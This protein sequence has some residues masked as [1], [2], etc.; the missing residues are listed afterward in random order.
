MNVATLTLRVGGNTETLSATVS[1]SNADDL[2]VTYASEDTAIAT[3]AANGVVTGLAPGT[4]RISATTVNNKIA[5]TTVTVTQPVTGMTLNAEN[6]SMYVSATSTL[7]ATV[8][9]ANASDKSVVWS[10]SD[11]SIAT[12]LAGVVTAK[13]RGRAV[14]TA[15]TVD[16]NIADVAVITVVQP[17]VSVT[18]NVTT[19]AMKVGGA[20]ATIT[21]TVLP[22]NADDRAVTFASVNSSIARVNAQGV[23]TAVAPGSVRITATTANGKSAYT[24]VTVTQPV[25]SLLLKSPATTL[26][27]KKTL[28]LTATIAPSNATNKNITWS[29]SNTKIATVSSTGVVTGKAVG[30]VKITAKTADGNFTKQVTLK[31]V[32]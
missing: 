14:I 13:T 17:A 32:K 10:T 2:S 26:K 4:V 19:L 12:V 15:T 21:A 31:V 20:T 30:S 27:L 11:S 29:S 22:A 8:L 5:Y 3:V 18:M 6:L 25:T 16:G 24:T 23:V 9:P 7:V 1:P 28:K